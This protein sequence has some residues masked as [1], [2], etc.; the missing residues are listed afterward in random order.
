MRRKKHFSQSE[1]ETAIR[2]L[3]H[4][5]LV[6]SWVEGQARFFELKEG[7]PE[8]EKFFKRN[9]REYAERLIK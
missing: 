9:S 3:M 4:T 7:T 5:K 2:V 1:I 6:I 8:Y